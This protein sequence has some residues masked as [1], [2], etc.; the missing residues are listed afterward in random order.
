MTTPNN[1]DKR[2]VIN[3]KCIEMKQ[4]NKIIK[5]NIMFLRGSLHESELSYSPDRSHS[6]AKTIGRSIIFVYMNEL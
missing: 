2:D 5:Y 6:V 3:D 1:E 4:V